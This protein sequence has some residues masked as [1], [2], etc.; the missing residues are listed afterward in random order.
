MSPST[1]QVLGFW[2]SSPNVV[3]AEIASRQGYR[4]AVLDIEHGSFDLAALDRFIPFARQLGFRV[5]AKVLAPERSPIQQALDF[6][7][8]LYTGIGVQKN[9]SRTTSTRSVLS[10]KDA[11]KKTAEVKRSGSGVLPGK[12]K[13]SSTSTTLSV[14]EETPA[15]DEPVRKKMHIESEKTKATTSRACAPWA[16]RNTP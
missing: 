1:E 3:A 2:F 5:M 6:G 7:I 8:N 16:R 14:K 9:L 10:T 15:E 12:R 11:N 4:N 13:T